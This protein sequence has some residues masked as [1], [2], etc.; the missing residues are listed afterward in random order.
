MEALTKRAMR[1]ILGAKEMISVVIVAVV[2][3][4]YVVVKTHQMDT[5]YCVKLYLSKVEF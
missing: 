5:L 2:A 1:Q 3:H 4:L